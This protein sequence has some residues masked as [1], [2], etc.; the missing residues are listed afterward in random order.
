MPGGNIRTGFLYDASRVK[1]DEKSVQRIDDPSFA[2]TR[3]PL[4]A[5]F[6]FTHGS[7]TERVTLASVHNKSK[8]S[9]AAET[10]DAREQQELAINAWAKKNAPKNDHEH[11]GAFGDRNAYTDEK[12]LQLEQKD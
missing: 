2:G 1:L 9:G 8:R 4:V 5:T 12:A 3:L 6:V 10:Q 7:Q 11:L